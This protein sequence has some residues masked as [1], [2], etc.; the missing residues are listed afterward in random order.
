MRLYVLVIVCLL[1]I[2]PVCNAA[3]PL[4]PSAVGSGMVADGIDKGVTKLADGVMDFSC[5]D[6][7]SLNI[8]NGTTS[9]KKRPTITEMIV[10][11]ATWQV[12]P[13][14]YKTVID[15]MGVSLCGAVVFMF[16][17]AMCGAASVALNRKANRNSIIFGGD[18][19]DSA[20]QHYGENIVVGCLSMSY[21]VLFIWAMLLISYIIKL[22][23]MNSIA[24]SIAPTATSSVMYF[25][26]A[27]MWACVAV[28][29][30]ISNIIICLT[31]AFSFIIGAL[32]ASDKTRHITRK[33][34]EYFTCA[35]ILQ[36]FVIAVAAVV[37]G[38]MMNI[39]NGPIGMIM[40]EKME[41]ATYF[42]MIILIVV[43]CFR[44]L[45]GNV[46]LLKK[47]AKL[48]KLVV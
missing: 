13:F 31:A 48:V 32:N 28:S 18:V 17:Y 22:M 4:N 19:N 37:V 35:L 6:N 7:T 29:F 23:I 41:M 45:F 10:G 40:P 27:C 26:M 5:G 25:S 21:I 36:V 1:L 20:L 42:G 16:M 47:S 12:T 43:G 9:V 15:M 33:C 11:F 24:D 30:A 8:T 39:K 3:S 14:K 38:I 46:H 44:I 2:L 34:L